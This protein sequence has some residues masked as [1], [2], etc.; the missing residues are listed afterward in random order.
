[1]MKLPNGTGSVYKLSGKRRKPYAAVV[2]KECVYDDDRDDYIQKRVYIG[3]YT[4][5]IEAI[6][7]LADYNENPFDLDFAKAT[8]K[9]IYEI[10]KKDFTDSRKNNYYAAYKYCESLYEMPVRDIRSAHLQA[11]IDTCHTTQQREIKTVFNKVFSYCMKNDIIQKNPALYVTVKREEP[12]KKRIIFTSEEINQIEESGTWWSDLTVIALYSGMRT[13]ELLELPADN[14]DI[15]NRIFHITKAKNKSSIRDIPIHSHIFPLVEKLISSGSEF[16]FL[17]ETNSKYV[18]DSINHAL[19]PMNHTI[20]ETRH[21]FATAAKKCNMDE[22][23]VQRIMG[24]TPKTITHSVYTHLTIE[25]L[26]TE[27]E[28]LNYK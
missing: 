3:Y 10:I 7:A 18:H 24:H 9:D 12:V 19:E 4:T 11:A 23:S 8:F 21:T 28:K 20:Y 17:P 6:K 5:K 22:L 25:D 16:P 1:M 14:I 15:E 26:R 2:T 13:K 27:I